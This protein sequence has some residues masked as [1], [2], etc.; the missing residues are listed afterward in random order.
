MTEYRLKLWYLTRVIANNMMNQNSIVNPTISTKSKMSGVWVKIKR[1]TMTMKPPAQPSRAGDTEIWPS[2]PRL[3]YL[4]LQGTANYWRWALLYAAL[5]VVETLSTVS[6]LRSQHVVG[7]F[8]IALVSQIARVQPSVFEQAWIRPA[9]GPKQHLGSRS[10]R[11]G[12]V[13][14]SLPRW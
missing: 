6:Q 5:K 11:P 14:H 8:K 12:T 7:S 13:D 10:N 2:T 4:T 1:A 9:C 3:S